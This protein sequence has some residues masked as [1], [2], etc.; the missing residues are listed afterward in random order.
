MQTTQTAPAES[1]S[2]QQNTPPSCVLEMSVVEADNIEQELHIKSKAN[3]HTVFKESYLITSIYNKTH[4]FP[5]N[6]THSNFSCSTK[7]VF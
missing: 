7:Q 6:K 3:S 4:C 5:K 2:S 1:D